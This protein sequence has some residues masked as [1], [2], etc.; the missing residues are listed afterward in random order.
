MRAF[1]SEEDSATLLQVGTFEDL[2]KIAISALGRMKEAGHEIV[3][4]CGPFTTGGLGSPELNGQRF[5]EARKA[6]EARNYVVF[7]QMPFEDA[8]KRIV[9]SY[10]LPQGEYCDDVLDVFY[11]TIFKSGH[12]SKFLFIPGWESSKGCRW[13][14]NEAQSLGIPCE[15]IP[16][17]WFQ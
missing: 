9:A 12:L 6:A 8:I 14:R 17:E 10:N 15:D 16:L 11:R 1:I 4:I 13:E 5:D 3:Q 7:D 2:A